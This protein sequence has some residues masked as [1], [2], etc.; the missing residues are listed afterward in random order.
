M[1]VKKDKE[2]REQELLS[3]YYKLKGDTVEVTL[4]YN[5]FSELVDPNFGDDSVE[6]LNNKLFDSIELAFQEI[7][8][9]YY[10]YLNIKVKDF[11]NY[12]QDEA[13][14]II[15]ENIEM[16]LHTIK[17][18]DIIRK[19][20]ST[21]IML[22]GV[23]IIAGSYLIKRTSTA[24]SLANEV[25]DLAGQVLV[26]EGMYAYFLEKTD[27]KLLTRQYRKKLHTIKIS[28]FGE[29]PSEDIKLQKV[30]KP[31]FQ[32][33]TLIKFDSDNKN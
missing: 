2:T 19:V 3:K 28:K 1:S 17:R 25:I 7:P 9:K 32:Q 6:K 13:I 21:L 26:W 12:N 5:T 23:F 11:G 20:V 33:T 15:R 18:V 31:Q 8:I 16:R 4:V 24:K 27:K 30:Q 14:K 10:I 29:E 22:A